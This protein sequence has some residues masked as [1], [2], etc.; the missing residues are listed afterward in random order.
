MNPKE[1]LS[2][3]QHRPFPLP[4]GP[5]LMKQ[6]WNDLLCAHWPVN[7]DDLLPL[8]PRGL[9]LE[10]WEGRPWISLIPFRL[11]PLRV[12]GVPPL[13]FVGDFLEFN[14][15]TYVTR[16]GKPGIFFLNLEASSPLAVAGARTF[17]HLPYHHAR[18]SIRYGDQETFRYVSVRPHHHADDVIFKGTYRPVSHQVVHAQ[19]G[20]LIHWLTERYCLYTLSP[21]GEILVGDIHHLPW[22]LQEAELEVDT[23][24]MTNYHGFDLA[25]PPSIVTYA[26]RLEVL[27]W[28][29]RKC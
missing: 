29:L 20:T 16:N 15:R 21:G 4:K 11:K 18:M 3:T 6:G 25:D 10:L 26:K 2:Y 17:A 19:P 12:R 14:V 13:P 5:W 28:A 8:I 9:D 23:N 7:T 24:M 1:I 22:P 27:F